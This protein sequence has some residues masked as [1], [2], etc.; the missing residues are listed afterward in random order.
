MSESGPSELEVEMRKPRGMAG[1]T[2]IWLVPLIALSLAGFMTWQSLAGRGPLIEITFNNGEGVVAGETE[3]KF[4]DVT[5][6]KVENVTFGTGLTNVIVEV[7][8]DKSI[9][10]YVDADAEFW[11]VRPEISAQGVSG[12]ATLLG[13]VFLEGAW[14]ADPG[15]PRSTFVGL[16]KQPL[17]SQN[18]EGVEFLLTAPLG[19]RIAAGAPILYKGVEVGLIDRPV[20][21][22]D[23]SLVTAQAFVRAPYHHLV[24]TG[25]RF[26]SAS[27]INVSLG[28]GGLKLDIGNLTS[29]IKGGV[30]FENLA[31][32]AQ[33]IGKG[34]SFSVFASRDAA[35]SASV[36]EVVGAEVPFSILFDGSIDGLATGAPVKFRG[37]T[38]GSVIGLGSFLDESGDEPKVMMRVDVRLLPDRFGISGDDAEVRTIELVAEQVGKGYRAQLVSQGLLGTSLRVDLVQVA[39]AP[40]ANLASLTTGRPVIPATASNITDVAGSMQTAAER[41]VNLPYE[42]MFKAVTDLIDH[43]NSVVASDGVQDAPAEVLG[44]IEDFRK[45]VGSDAVTEA[46]T[47][48]AASLVSLKSILDQVQ[49]SEAAASLVAT[50][51]STEQVASRVAEV[52]N[53]LPQ[54]TAEIQ[55]LL[56]KAND[57]PLDQ[58]IEEATAVVASANTVISSPDFTTMPDSLTR[59]LA[60]V[61]TSV[62]DVRKMVNE[63]AASTAVD[64]LVAAMAR[65]DTIAK[66]VEGTVSGLDP[67]IANIQTLASTAAGLP[68]QDLV[69]RAATLVASVDAVASSPDTQALPGQLNAALQTVTATV[70]DVEQITSRLREGPE[71]DALL[72]ALGRTD[73]IAQ[74]IESASAG[75]PDLVARIDAVARTAEELP[76]NELMASATSLVNSA[77]ALVSSDE[78]AQIP[79][80]LAYALDELGAALAELREGG[81]VANTNAML[82]S[83]SSAADAVAAAAADLPELAARLDGLVRQSEALMATYGERSQFSAQTL[84]AIRD[85]R[86][87]AQAVTSLARTIERKPN[88]LLVGR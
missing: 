55:A 58:L 18:E 10:P 24:T 39:D 6:G 72:A 50:L 45:L 51:K 8:L 79:P 23:G 43:V 28:T 86:D 68:L 70:A 32:D 31:L 74:S 15:M 53:G 30:A 80:A 46:V 48:A 88:S 60:D 3:L 52:S 14:D 77:E 44:L 12:L 38:V 73:E 75:L 26:W 2:M 71:V 82:A 78:T 62:G 54:I 40:P 35:G 16:A 36:I 83:A 13:G 61:E 59:I 49:Q 66:D 34:H 1:L 11:I 63:F 85:M 67:I 29:I 41:I 17:F 21:S 20:L 69:S 4:R 19:G 47:D 22:D 57:L 42:D 37:L 56:V 25:T 84:A 27:G 7:R 64:S 76:L 5:V 87:A 33:E 9:A 81:A 65:V